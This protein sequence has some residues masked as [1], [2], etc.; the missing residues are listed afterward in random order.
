M[1]LGVEVMV[2]PI[3]I[4]NMNYTVELH[5][6]DMGGHAVFTEQRKECVR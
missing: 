6:F 3:K 4:P 5:I 2:S 1:T